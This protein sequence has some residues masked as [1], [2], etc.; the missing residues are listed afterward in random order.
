MN[1]QIAG[2][3]AYAYSGGRPFD[4]D[5]PLVVFIHGASHDHSVWALQSRYLA[6]HGHSVLAL[7]L[8]G[9]GRSPGPPLATVPALADWVLDAIASV[10]AEPAAPADPPPLFLVGHSMG[11][12]IALEASHRAQSHPA[13]ARLRLD[14]LV[15][16]GT[17]V[18]M[19]VSDALLQAADGDE[20]RAFDM[21]NVWSHSGLNHPTGTSAP[22]FSVFISNRRLMERQPHGVLA[23]DLRAC[24]DYADGLERAKAFR[25]PVLL[26]L[27]SADQM[28]PPRAARALAEALPCA[29]TVTIAGA[30]H[31]L[32]TERPDEVLAALR[33]W[34]SARSANAAA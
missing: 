7:D 20:P 26:V 5:R 29:H 21:V 12:L 2:R 27:G 17:A 15:L 30:G 31:A 10:R 3:P 9:H 11:S 8:P 34:L 16:V 18:P 14:G 23:C 33:N 25:P 22:G 28:T 1:L 13:A 24:N 4:H 6:H 19:R 32:M